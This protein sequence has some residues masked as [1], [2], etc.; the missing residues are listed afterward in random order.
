MAA[1]K[2]KSGMSNG[3]KRFLI[4]F[5]AVILLSALGLGWSFYRKVYAP[6]VRMAQ[7]KSGYIY[8]PTGS[9]FMDVMRLLQQEGVLM[10]SATFEWVA[11]QMKYINQV[12]PGRYYIKNGISNRELVGLLRSGRQVPL[13]LTFS[14]IRTVEQLAGIAGSKLEAD[15][16]AIAFLFK[17]KAWLEK[18]GFNPQN[19]L[20]ILIPNTYEFNWNTSAEQFFERIARE[21][22]IFWN[23]ARMKKLQQTGLTQSQVSTLASIVEQETRRNDEKAMIAGVY[24]NRYLKGWKL[25]A[26]PTLVYASGNFGLRRVLNEHKEIDSPYNTYMYTGLPPGPICMPSIASIDAVL[27]YKR[28]EYMFFCAREDFTGYHSFAKTYDQHLLNARRYQKELSRRGIRS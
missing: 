14:N 26:D 1:R 24:M 6:N 17:D 2:K 23:E 7:R 21:Y 20:S 8:I 5:T 15:S 10:N 13:R 22:K 12:N 16:Q 3:F 4:A 19:S 11:G 25:E 27:N 28:H 9:R 18:Y